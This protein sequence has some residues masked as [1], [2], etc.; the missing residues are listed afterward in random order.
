MKQKEQKVN[1]IGA[2]LRGGAGDGGSTAIGRSG[3]SGGKAGSA[4]RCFPP[5]AV[6]LT[7]GHLDHFY[8]QSIQTIILVVP[9]VIQFFL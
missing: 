1:D 8:L 7:L 2:P 3:W 4:E 6:L 5:L 9:G